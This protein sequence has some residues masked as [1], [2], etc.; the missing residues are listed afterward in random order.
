MI[1]SVI[2]DVH[3]NPWKF[4]F[5]PFFGLIVLFGAVANVKKEVPKGDPGAPKFGTKL[6]NWYI[7]GFAVL[8]TSI[9]TLFAWNETF[10]VIRALDLGAYQRVEGP[11]THFYQTA[12]KGHASELFSVGSI[13]FHHF[14]YDAR[15]TFSNKI[16]DPG[17]LRE[18]IPVRISYRGDQVLK[19]E[20]GTKPGQSRP[21]CHEKDAPR[22]LPINGPSVWHDK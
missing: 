16:I 20:I 18:G 11:L 9:A 14:D 7:V 12:W 3:D 13:R 2:F 1:W 8:W 10:G 21:N 19:L 15:S 17:C 6:I 4:L 5:F 22:F